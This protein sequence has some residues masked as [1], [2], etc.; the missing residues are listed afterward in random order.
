MTEAML[1]VRDAVR[2]DAEGIVALAAASGLFD[3]GDLAAFAPM[4]REGVGGEA[5]WLVAGD[6]E[7]AAFAEPEGFADRVWNLRFIAMRPGAR[8]GGGGS[9]LLAAV[10]ARL[11]GLGA[12]L[13]LIDT[14][15][16][17]DFAPARAFY[18]ANGY[19]VEARIR[20]YYAEAVDRVIFARRL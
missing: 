8:R 19:A 10:E 7:G 2:S 3:E 4:I 16:G 12:R 11:R 13:L 6:T 17:E 18:T 5:L 14:G 20:D 9:A 1:M 15:G